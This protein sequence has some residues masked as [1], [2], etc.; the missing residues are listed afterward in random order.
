MR[1]ERRGRVRRAHEGASGSA[2]A[3]IELRRGARLPSW[4]S[5]CAPAP[6]EPP[7]CRHH[8]HPA[9]TTAT[10]PSPA[11]PCHHQPH[12]AITSPSPQRTAR[13]GCCA[14]S[15]PGLDP[16]SGAR[17]A[18]QQQ[19]AAGQGWSSSRRGVAGSIAV[20]TAAGG[21]PTPRQWP[22]PSATHTHTGMRPCP[23]SPQPH[24]RRHHVHVLALVHHRLYQAQRHLFDAA[25]ET[26]QEAAASGVG[27]R[28]GREQATG[29]TRAAMRAATGAHPPARP[30]VPR[31]RTCA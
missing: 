13:L 8:H 15:R 31:A 10:L 19:G 29:G 4:P 22:A 6:C 25:G 7:P 27:A 14:R 20:S 23:A 17:T 16:S 9:I 2:G 26:K 12:P 18:Q 11:P 21:R 5:L 30:A 24:L 1:G 28:H 3:G